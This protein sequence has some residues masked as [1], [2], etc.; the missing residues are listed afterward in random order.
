MKNTPTS[1]TTALVSDLAQPYLI[2]DMEFTSGTV[3]LTNLPY[4]IVV[5]GNT[6]IADGGLTELEPPQLTS[7]LDREVYRI[8]LV[9]FNN[10]YK[11]HFDN[12]A[13]GTPATVRLGITGNTTEFDVVYK[14]R[15]DG[16]SIQTNPKEGTKD[17]I[18]ECSSPFAALDR[19]NS[20]MTDKNH[21]RNINP[22]DSSMDYVYSA[23]KE[24]ELKWGKV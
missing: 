14:G 22:N 11:A 4:D 12:S 21:Q 16:V 5:G 9:D 19:T 17:A 3:R 10:I 2:L 24:V 6:Y 20:R 15:I 23:A 8:K 1:I 13:L 18:I 7:I